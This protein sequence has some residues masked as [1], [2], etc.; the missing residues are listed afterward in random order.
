ADELRRQRDPD[1]LRRTCN[2]AAHRSREPPPDARDGAVSAATS[3]AG[4]DARATGGKTIMIM[5]GGTGG[6]IFP[7]RAVAESLR[8]RNWRVVW[9]GNPAGMEATLVPQR[10]IDMKPVRFSGLRGKGLLTALLLPFNLTRALWQSRR[11]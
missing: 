9:M 11:A 5:A 7:G 10:G 6:H 3:T 1:D 2:R 8:E 4:S